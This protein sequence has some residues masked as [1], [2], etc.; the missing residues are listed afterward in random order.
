MNELWAFKAMGLIIWKFWEFS[1]FPFENLR[2]VH[3]FDVFLIVNHK[4]Y[5][6]EESGASS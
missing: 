1:K 6:K 4:I 5:Y 2:I 3:H